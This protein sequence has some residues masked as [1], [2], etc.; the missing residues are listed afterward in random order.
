VWPR[1]LLVCATSGP[2]VSQSTAGPCRIGPALSQNQC[3]RAEKQYG[4]SWSCDGA[5]RQ[6]NEPTS[7]YCPDR[8]L[9]R[10][11][12][13]DRGILA[14]GVVIKTDPSRGSRG[15]LA[16]T[17]AHIGD[18]HALTVFY[19]DRV[20]VFCKTRL[21]GS[22]R[23]WRSCRSCLRKTC[24]KCKSPN[25]IWFVWRRYSHRLFLQSPPSARIA[26]MRHERP[27]PKELP[28]PEV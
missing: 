1:F 13:V 12:L 9:F 25:V 24:L 22:R 3:L 4:R 27:Q 2:R 15:Q 20:T 16:A 10:A 26:P 11:A 6:T 19:E 8:K 28:V 7:N 23:T 18:R 21:G 17:A 5:K 14:S